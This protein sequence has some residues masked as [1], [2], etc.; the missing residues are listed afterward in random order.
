MP[1]ATKFKESEVF[2][3]LNNE[4]TKTV[5]EKENESK[6]WTSFLQRPARPKPK[7]PEEISKE[8]S[9]KPEQYQVKIVKQPKPKLAPDYKE[10]PK[11]VSLYKKYP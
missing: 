8:Y 2:K 1:T 3:T 6:K 11:P 4:V 9:P 10:E 7:T 5:E